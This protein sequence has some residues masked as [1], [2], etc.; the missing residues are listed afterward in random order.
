MLFR[1]T[2]DFNLMVQGG[3]SA[4]MQRVNGNFKMTVST[5][6]VIATYANNERAIVQIGNEIYELSPHSFGWA[7]VDANTA[8][9]VQANDALLMEIDV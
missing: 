6:K 4:D 8:I 2:Q 9:Y 3:A 7:L 5:P 1:S